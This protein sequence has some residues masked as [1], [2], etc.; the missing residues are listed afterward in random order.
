MNFK[1]HGVCS[2]GRIGEDEK[3]SLCQ[4]D[5]CPIFLEMNAVTI[6]LAIGGFTNP[7]IFVV[8][9]LDEDFWDKMIWKPLS[10]VNFI[11]TTIG[12]M[13]IVYTFVKHYFSV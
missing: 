10:R 13:W 1:I 9:V 2:V 11:I 7:S 4:R 6:F 8:A 5:I 12:F 3:K